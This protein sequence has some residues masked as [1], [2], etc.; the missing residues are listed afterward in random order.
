MFER[1]L[2]QV[3]LYAELMLQMLMVAA[4]VFDAFS[5]GVCPLLTVLESMN[6]N[7]I[8]KYRQTE[9]S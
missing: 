3:K 2:L 7:C 9:M 1:N 5:G 6:L 8:T 4:V